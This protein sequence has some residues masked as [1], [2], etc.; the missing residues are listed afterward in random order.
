MVLNRFFFAKKHVRKNLFFLPYSLSL[1]IVIIK[2][3]FRN[4]ENSFFCH[5]CA[6]SEKLGFFLFNL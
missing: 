3:P 5:K 1:F 6:N 4:M 2:R